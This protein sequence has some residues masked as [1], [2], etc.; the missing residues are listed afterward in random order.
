M[1]LSHLKLVEFKH[2]TTNQKMAPSIVDG[3]DIAQN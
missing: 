2:K 1:G 3:A